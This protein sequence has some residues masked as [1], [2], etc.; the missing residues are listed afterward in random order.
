MYMYYDNERQIED[1]NN[2]AMMKFSLKTCF[3]RRKFDKSGRNFLNFNLLN[4]YIKGTIRVTFCTNLYY[5]YKGCNKGDL[6]YTVT[7]QFTKTP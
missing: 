6:W 7:S 5:M 3:H 2:K 1:I 4:L